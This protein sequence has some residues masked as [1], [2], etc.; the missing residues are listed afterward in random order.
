MIPK[1]SGPARPLPK[2]DLDRAIREQLIEKLESS[3]MLPLQKS[4]GPRLARSSD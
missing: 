3:P 1:Q 4:V 2:F